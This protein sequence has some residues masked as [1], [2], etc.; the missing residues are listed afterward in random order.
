MK[1]GRQRLL[2]ARPIM[3]TL[4]L[5]LMCNADTQSIA[6]PHA[7]RTLTSQTQIPSTDRA[8]RQ[9]VGCKQ[10]A[11]PNHGQALQANRLHQLPN[12]QGEGG[13]GKKDF[14]I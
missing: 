10:L 12:C 2:P 1:A 13:G 6:N 5:W 9:W 4:I 3:E 8:A 7:P 11:G 14:T